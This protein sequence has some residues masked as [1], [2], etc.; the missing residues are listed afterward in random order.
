MAPAM[1]R[2]RRVIGAL[3]ALVLA[4]TGLTALAPVERAEALSGSQF[5]PGYIISDQYFYDANAMSVAQIQSFLDAKIGACA[6]SN[7]LNVLNTQ[8]VQKAARYSTGGVLVCKAYDLATPTAIESAATIIFKVQQACS[9]S[10]KVLLVTL[11]KEQ[12]L[13]TKK[14]VTAGVLERAMG[15]GCPDSAGGAC[16]S[17]YYGFFNQVYWAAWQLKRYGT[18]PAVGSYQPGWENI[19]Y[20]PVVGCGAS[21]V[22]IQNNATAALY[23]YTPYQPNGPALANLGGTG[24]ACS[25]YGNRNFW[26]YYNTWFGTSTLPP[27]TP[28]GNLASVTPVD[29]GVRI[30]GWAVDP[31]AP[32][33]VVALSIQFGNNW[34]V[35]YADK[36]GEDLSSRFPGSGTRHTFSAT[37]PAVPG[38]YS[39]CI[40]PVNAGGAGASGTMGCTAVVV[41]PPPLPLGA[42]DSATVSNGVVSFSGWLVRPNA[43][44]TSV[45][46]AINVG[47]TWIGVTGNQPNAIAPTVVAGAGPNQGFTGSFPAPPGLTT[48]CLWASPIGLPAKSIACRSILVPDVA[49]TVAAIETA[50][51]TPTSISM[52]GW[53]V[54]PGSTAT[55]VPMAVN[56][57]SSWYAVVADKPS[58]SAQVGVPN[59]GPNHGFTFSAPATPGT[60]PVCLWTSQPTGGA[61]T[62]VGC[63]T[64]TVA[65]APPTT[66]GVVETMAAGPGSVSLSGWA[67]WTDKPASSV[68]MAVQ[69]DSTWYALT[70]DKPSTAAA[71]ALPGIGA[72]H[73]FSGTYS[74][75]PGPHLVCIWI[76][77]STGTA[78]ALECRTITP[79]AAFAT[80]GGLTTATGASGGIHVDGWAV[81][82]STP[83]ATVNL[84]ANIGGLWV[85]LATGRPNALAPTKFSGAGPNQGFSALVPIAPGTHSVCLWAGG[86][87]GAVN[88]GCST[89]TVTPAPP[90]VVDFSSAT[91]V[92]GGIAVSGWA[93][94]PTAPT[95]GVNVAANIGSTW[96]S[97]PSTL[98]NPLTGD[99]VA[100]AGPNQGFAG[101]VPAA[102]GARTVCIWASQP[103]GPAVQVGCKTITVV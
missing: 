66:Q 33:A 73:G 93:A 26:V 98:A 22:F 20:H 10:A 81:M 85:P 96:I 86:A 29:G 92:A 48:L 68:P 2:H 103:S 89:A 69:I 97:L 21:A 24:D 77:Q 87:T 40:Y 38:S 35:A 51:T 67:A 39:M 44:T 55:A 63:R 23:N 17:E 100:G 6:N 16:A 42:I 84:A 1:S 58:A 99:F 32:T 72:N 95:T 54:W 70:A 7:C 76:T 49:K 101:T 30:D 31:D 56:I 53:A 52:T 27:G 78:K 59:S 34:F 94:W 43:L 75:S 46:G 14:S 79:G 8:S 12:G 19:Q 50:T 5:N 4:A 60:Y 47:S 90:V 9:I 28:E 15:Y 71:A 74:L 41:P 62:Q 11:Q 36:E 3:I 18:S 102:A 13:V 91:A 80:V 37:L 88:I 82:P 61:A 83:T 65:T 64:V 45:A 25:A 57:G